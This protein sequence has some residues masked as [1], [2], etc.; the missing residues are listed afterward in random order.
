M[1]SSI[2]GIF[3]QA[4][5]CYLK[6]DELQQI[7][8]YVTSIADR[9]S[10]YRAV[11]DREIDL[12]QQAVDELQLEMPALE[13]A[14]LERTL[15][16]GMLAL[17]HCAMA[18]LINDSGYMQTRLLSWLESSIELHKAQGIDA[19]FFRLIKQQLRFS[20]NTQQM[21]LLE[22]FLSLVETVVSTQEE[23]MLTVAGI[24]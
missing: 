22:P 12:I 5:N 20:L 8:Q 11:R 9:I 14:V 7:G 10:T 1:Q 2:E 3:D 19:A 23:E 6:P 15:K 21:T 18:M 13:I 4:E 16:N 24:F 17:R